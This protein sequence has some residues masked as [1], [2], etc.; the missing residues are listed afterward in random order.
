M[1]WRIAV[2]MLYAGTTFGA[3]ERGPRR[4]HQDRGDDGCADER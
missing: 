3:A 4:A 1:V 2:D